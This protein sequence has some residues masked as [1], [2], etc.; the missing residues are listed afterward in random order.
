MLIK[1]TLHKFIVTNMNFLKIKIILLTLIQ[2][3]MNVLIVFLITDNQ[4]KYA[5]MQPRDQS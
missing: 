1:F 5:G 3:T 4:S 2:T